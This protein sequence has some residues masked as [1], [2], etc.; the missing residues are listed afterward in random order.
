MSVLANPGTTPLTADGLVKA[1]AG[2]FD[3]SD[4]SI[5]AYDED[6]VPVPAPAINAVGSTSVLETGNPNT[7]KNAVLTIPFGW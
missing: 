7:G 6:G 1:D 4:I 2:K 5:S 3:I